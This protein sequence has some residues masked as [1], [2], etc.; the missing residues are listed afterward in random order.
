MSV[1][2]QV[3]DDIGAERRDSLIEALLRRAKL[4]EGHIGAVLSQGHPA[5]E[6]LCHSCSGMI[7]LW[8]PRAELIP[9]GGGIADKIL[10]WNSILSRSVG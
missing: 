9:R 7:D 10:L 4:L 6:K 2:S 3:G 5:I 8:V 1:H